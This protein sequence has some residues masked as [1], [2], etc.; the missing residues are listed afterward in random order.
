MYSRPFI[1]ED[2]ETVITLDLG[3]YPV[4]PSGHKA[5]LLDEWEVPATE[6]VVDHKLGEG[7]FGEVYKGAIRGP[8]RNPKISSLLRQSI[9]VPVAIKFLKCEYEINPWTS[10]YLYCLK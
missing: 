7:E 9:G 4:E 10:G 6:L 5:P 2:P 3:S 1:Q 8:L